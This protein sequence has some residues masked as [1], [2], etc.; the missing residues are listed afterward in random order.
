[1]STLETIIKTDKDIRAILRPT[2]DRILVQRDDAPKFTETGFKIPDSSQ[3]FKPHSGIVL[4]VGQRVVEV[5]RDTWIMFGRGSGT[6]VTIN[7]Q[8]FVLMREPDAMFD[9]NTLEPFDD[10]IILIPDALPKMIRGIHVPDNSNEQPQSGKIVTV[11]K[12][13]EDIRPGVQ[14]LFGKFSG[15]SFSLKNQDY[16]IIREADIFAE[17]E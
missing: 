1:M 14:V 10:R 8:T 9:M 15:M 11:G 6:E 13:C 2:G 7:G 3:S 17:I 16:K 5:K 12:E 4:A